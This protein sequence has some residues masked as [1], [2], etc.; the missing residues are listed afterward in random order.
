MSQCLITD[1][2]PLLKQVGAGARDPEVIC[3]RDERRISAQPGNN[4]G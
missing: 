3:G 2:N 4:D 1:N